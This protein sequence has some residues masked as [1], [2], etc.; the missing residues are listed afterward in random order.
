MCMGPSGA[1]CVL[2]PHG[3]FSL[4]PVNEPIAVLLSGKCQAGAAGGWCT[5]LVLLWKVGPH[6]DDAVVCFPPVLVC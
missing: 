5:R 3:F 2:P 1:A 4:H 6:L